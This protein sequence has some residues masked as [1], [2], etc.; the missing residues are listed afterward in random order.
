MAQTKPYRIGLIG[1]GDMAGAHINGIKNHAPHLKMTAICD[2]REVALAKTG[3]QLGIPPE[4]RYA[5]FRELIADEEVDA[6]L[7]VT[8]NVVHAEIMALCLAAGKPFLSEKPFTMSLQEANGLLQIYEAQPVPAMIGFS[9]RYTPAFRFVRQLLKDGRIG[10]VRHFSVQYLQ[11]WG[12]AAYDTP[13]LWRFDK[14]V[15]GTGTL[16]DLGA[17]MID[18][19][20]YLIGSFEELSAHLQTIVAERR[21]LQSG[22]SVPVEVDDLACFHAVMKNGAVGVFQTTRNAIGSGNQLDIAIY[23]DSGTLRASTEDPEHVVWIHRDA[24]TG[25]RI[26]K[27]LDVPH[28]VKL[29]QWED[30]ARLLAGSPSD[31]LPGFMAGYESQQVLDAILRAHE[32]KRTVAVREEGSK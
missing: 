20:H 23:G 22:E 28:A 10:G 16:G 7:S 11:E 18:L 29:S 21:S 32:E 31:G 24:E 6:V 8:P 13:F 3:D 19:A 17:H 15:T 5:D 9:Y 4:R 30:F 27:R 25:G 1:L 12:S 14:N 2:V 26:E